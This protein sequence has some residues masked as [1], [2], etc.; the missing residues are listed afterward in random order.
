MLGKTFPE[1]VLV[2]EFHGMLKINNQYLILPKLTEVQS[3]QFEK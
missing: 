2:K 1:N 3:K